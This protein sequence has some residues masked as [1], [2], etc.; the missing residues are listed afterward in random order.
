[1][2]S[3][4]IPRENNLIRNITSLGED[5]RN[6]SSSNSIC[7]PNKTTT[8]LQDHPCKFLETKSGFDSVFPG[9]ANPGNNESYAPEVP[10]TTS[11]VFEAGQLNNKQ[12][13]TRVIYEDETDAKSK[14]PDASSRSTPTVMNEQD[15]KGS[16]IETP[17]EAKAKRKRSKRNPTPTPLITSS[18]DLGIQTL[19]AVGIEST[20]VKE[21]TPLMHQ[22][23]KVPRKKRR[24]DDD[25]VRHPFCLTIDECFNFNRKLC[26]NSILHLI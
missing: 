3:S 8:S 5:D 12:E 16:E 1:L 4:A 14:L 10:T 25:L 20:P 6:T 11:A 22:P 21:T 15:T 19:N 9:Q 18:T 13:E 26:N 7:N 17:K 24:K 23:P 2:I